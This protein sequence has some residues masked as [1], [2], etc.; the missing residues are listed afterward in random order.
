MTVE[1]KREAV[2]VGTNSKCEVDATKRLTAMFAHPCP[3]R[4]DS[5][6]LVSKINVEV[7]RSKCHLEPGGPGLLGTPVLE[8][9][10]E[11]GEG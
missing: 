8:Y 4:R 3:S 7:L 1:G 10:L 6:L 2:G 5:A 9:H 11:S